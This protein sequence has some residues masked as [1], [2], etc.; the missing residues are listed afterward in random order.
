VVQLTRAGGI[1]LNADQVS[2]KFKVYRRR[3]F[4]SER[5]G[6]RYISDGDK[7]GTLSGSHRSKKRYVS[8]SDCLGTDWRVTS[9]N[10]TS[11]GGTITIVG[12]KHTHGI[13]HVRRR[14]TAG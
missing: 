1:E 4:H 10:N 12:A 9:L 13:A 11:G 2:R 14:P 8:D 3:R 7:V 6:Q 5:G